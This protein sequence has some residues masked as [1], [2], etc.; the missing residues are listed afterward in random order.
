MRA[1]GLFVLLN[2]CNIAVSFFR[3]HRVLYCPEFF[4]VKRRYSRFTLVD[5]VDPHEVSNALAK[6]NQ[7]VPAGWDKKS[8][9]G[10]LWLYFVSESKL[11]FEIVSLLKVKNTITM[12]VLE[13]LCGIWTTFRLQ[14][15]LQRIACFSKSWKLIFC[16]ICNRVSKHR[17]VADIMIKIGY[18][19]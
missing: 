12:K 11:I 9:P 18:E 6:V 2:G 7:I 8:D 14:F 1:L 3:E 13:R 16:A 17:I 4:W 15:H 10:G 5:L 19:L